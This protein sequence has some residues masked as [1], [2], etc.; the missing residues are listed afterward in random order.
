MNMSFTGSWQKI[1]PR[2]IGFIAGDEIRVV[3]ALDNVLYNETQFHLGD[4]GVMKMYLK[5]KIIDGVHGLQ[6]VVGKMDLQKNGDSLHNSVSGFY[7]EKYQSLTLFFSRGYENNHVGLD[8]L[9]SSADESMRSSAINS[10]DTKS[11]QV[12]RVWDYELDPND[13]R[14]RPIFGERDF[15]KDCYFRFDFNLAADSLEGKMKMVNMSGVGTGINC[16]ETLSLSVSGYELNIRSAIRKA[17]LFA[18]LETISA[19]AQIAVVIVLLNE[20]NSQAVAQ[21]ISIYSIAMMCVLDNFHCAIYLGS[22]MLH[23]NLV[24][25]FFFVAFLKVLLYAVFEMRLVLFIWKADHNNELWSDSHGF[26]RIIHERM[27]SLILVSWFLLFWFRFHYRI[28]W[29]VAYSFWVPQIYTNVVREARY[30]FGI[31]FLAIMSITRLLV[32]LYL[33]GCPENFVFLLV[34][35]P[36]H[37]LDPV[38]CYMLVCW[39]MIQVGILALQRRFGS[40]VIVPKRFLPEKYDYN[41]KIPDQLRDE[42]CVICMQPVTGV[43]IEHMLTPCNHLYHKDCLLQWTH[44]KLECPTCRTQLPPT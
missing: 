7:I 35:P 15:S 4:Q 43:D 17:S 6:H 19:V 8:F 37:L 1:E 10:L 21:K 13:G 20:A 42:D 30:P 27:Y 26:N 31:E 24:G 11:A 36:L 18:L 39:V 28:L 29:L 14:R 2:G 22:G 34:P 25:I 40:I 16:Q 32:P 41:R 3:S 33:H 38:T 12:I 23:E 5:S 9:N 44:Q